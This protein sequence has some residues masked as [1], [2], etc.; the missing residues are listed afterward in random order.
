MSKPRILVLDNSV[1][2]TGSIVSSMQDCTALKDDF[3]FIFMVPRKSAVVPLVRDAGFAV[4]EIPFLEIAKSWKL[5]I[6]LPVLFINVFRLRKIIGRH[7]PSLIVVN[8]LYNLVAS[9]YRAT[10]GKVPYVTFVRFVP[11]RFPP[12]LL[13]IWFRLHHRLAEYI[14]AVSNAAARDLSGPKVVTIYHHHPNGRFGPFP[15]DPSSRVI[16]YLANYI[17]GKGQQYAI[18]A[19]AQLTADFP[20]WTIRFVGGD[21]GLKKNHRFRNVLQQL[22]KEMG[23]ESIVT[24]D[25]PASDVVPEYKNAAIILNF[26][27][28]E[29]FSLTCMEAMTI[30]RPVIATRCGGPEEMITPGF[31]GELVNKEDISA[32]AGAMKKL[33]GDAELRTFQG[34][35]AAESVRSKFSPENTTGRLEHLYKQ[36]LS[37][38]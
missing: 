5:L 34:Q 17:P 11:N 29:S 15:L 28:S 2:V 4:E 25:G 37:K 33:M 21:M 18:K 36:V 32:M 23:I 24:F 6:Y 7:E 10:G 8:D 1:A 14:I 20:G 35:R 22:A 3:D 38:R 31:D 19:M 27:D 9:F 30:G 13:G 16:L 12:L 26:S